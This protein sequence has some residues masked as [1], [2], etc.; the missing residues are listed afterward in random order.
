M[1]KANKIFL[2]Q[3]EN[4][5][6]DN[7]ANVIA[8]ICESENEWNSGNQYYDSKDAYKCIKMTMDSI[9]K[10]Y[11]GE[12]KDAVPVGSIEFCNEVARLQG[13]NRIRALNIPDDLRSHKYTNRKIVVIDNFKDLEEY[14]DNNPDVVI[15]PADEA[16]KFEAIRFDGK[17][18]TRDYLRNQGGPYFVSDLIKGDIVSEWRI[19]FAY[20]KIVG[21]HPYS[22]EEW[23]M[24]DRDVVNDM[25]N[26]WKHDVPPTGTI[27]IGVVKDNDKIY[28]TIIEVHQLIACGLYGFEDSALLN[29]LRLAWRWHKGN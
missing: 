27:D 8:N 1:S 26:S 24:P 22:I 23:I 29:M 12:Y 21:I 7:D 2:I 25:L 6:I 20:G 14:I 4:E 15:K 16:K 3:C 18:Y 5:M 11:K 28:T 9:N 10:E 17:Q 19:F 13:A